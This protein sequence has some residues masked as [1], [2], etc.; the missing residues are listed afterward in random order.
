MSEAKRI[1]RNASYLF[2]GAAIADTSA[3][4]FRVLIANELGASG[5]GLFSLALMT[6]NVSTSITLLGLPDGVIT[7]VSRYRSNGQ[8]DRIAGVVL[9]TGV[10]TLVLNILV[11]S[12]IWKLAPVLATTLFD[13]S[14]LTKLLRI[15]VLGVPAKTIIALSGSICLSYERAGFQTTIRRLVPKIGMLL[16]AV[17]VIFAGGGIETVVTWYVLVLWLTA[18][19]GIGLSYVLLREESMHGITTNSKELLTFSIPLFLSGF[20]G[21][22]LNWTDTVLVGYFL[23]STD[24]G[25]YQ[26]AFLL[27]TSISMFT[28]AVGNSLY[29]NF[30]S[31]LADDRYAVLRDRYKTGVRWLA[32][33][34]AA[35]VIYL[36]AFPNISLDLIFGPEFVAGRNVLRFIIVSQFCTVVFGPATNTLKIMGQSRFILLTYLGGLSLNIGLNL[37]LIPRYGILGAAVGTATGLVLTNFLH[38]WRLQKQL[39]LS[40]PIRN[41]I[42]VVWIGGVCAVILKLWGPSVHSLS[43]FVFHILAFC[44]LY[45]TGLLLTGAVSPEELYDIVRS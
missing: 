25:V 43:L 7:F 23:T 35:P 1:F 40:I 10:V 14:G 21:F 42:Q 22:F 36:V 38:L 19:L 4:L 20:I 12:A 11:V 27:G 8:G 2:I 30:G 37:L 13:T 39:E 3:F 34:T 24:V 15:F 26:S 9:V 33:I 16:V 17:A 45:A 28:S 6:V 5:F 44:I 32:I 41:S 29:P 18:F 31:L